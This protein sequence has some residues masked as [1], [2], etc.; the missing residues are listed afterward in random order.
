MNP[1]HREYLPKSGL[2]TEEMKQMQREIGKKAVFLDDF[3]FD[4]DNLQD[5]TVVGVDQGFTDDKSVSVAV[6]MKNGEVVEEVSAAEDTPIP[7]IPGLL[8]FREG[9]AIVKA[10]NKLETDPDL[11]MLDGSGRIHFRQAGIATHIGLIFDVPAVGVAKKLL[12]GEVDLPEKMPTGER[13]KIF[14]DDKVEGLDKEVIGY[15]YQSSQYSSPNR[16][17]NPLY[18]SPGNRL[19]PETSVKTVSNLCKGYKLPEPTRLADKKVNEVK[20]K[21]S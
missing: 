12:C 8:A 21:Y 4:L 9:G 2:E 17:I 1:E 3:S 13:R 7:Y 11:L 6:A 15:A 18:I 16:S 10:L 20:K 19:S 14:A 5:L